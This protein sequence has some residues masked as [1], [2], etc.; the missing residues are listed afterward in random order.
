MRLDC[1]R[2]MILAMSAHQER[3]LSL[4]TDCRVALGER[5]VCT[6]GQRWTS[7]ALAGSDCTRYPPL[8]AATLSGW[9]TLAW[10]K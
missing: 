4:S 10:K 1:P 7:S 6:R 5:L 3:Y 9:E 8:S 2:L